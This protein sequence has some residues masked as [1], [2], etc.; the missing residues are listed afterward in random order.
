MLEKD[1]RCRKRGASPPRRF[2]WSDSPT[3][4]PPS[5]VQLLIRNMCLFSPACFLHM[6]LN[7]SLCKTDWLNRKARHASSPKWHTRSKPC[8]LVHAC[9]RELVPKAYHTDG[10]C[11]SLCMVR[12]HLYRRC[13]QAPLIM[14]PVRVTL[15]QVYSG[16]EVTV[17][18]TR[19]RFC[20]VCHGAGALPENL[21]S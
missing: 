16:I 1:Q 21:A 20:P 9:A 14:I 6:A 8:R 5:L 15:E 10:T 2:R 4:A 18:T 3:A 11:C 7:N 12:Y 17:N 13:M 19:S